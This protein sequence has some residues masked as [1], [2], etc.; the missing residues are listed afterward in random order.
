M[1]TIVV[2]VEGPV[3]SWMRTDPVQ[4]RPIHT[5]PL[6]SDGD[7]VCDYHIVP[8]SGW[9]SVFR[10]LMS[11]HCPVPLPVRGLCYEAIHGRGRGTQPALDVH[12][13]DD[14]KGT[15]NFQFLVRIPLMSCS[16]FW[17]FDV[18]FACES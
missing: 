5:I 9:L 1:H 13:H 8:W 2:E 4:L 16:F 11:S 10:T 18:W 12:L 6:L 14:S 7:A 15:F 3:R 17:E